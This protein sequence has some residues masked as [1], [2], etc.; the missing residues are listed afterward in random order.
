MDTDH[1]PQS[2]GDRAGLEAGGNVRRDAYWVSLSARDDAEPFGAARGGGIVLNARG[3]ALAAAW[4]ELGDLREGVE[5]DAVLIG[6]R[7]LEG[8]LLLPGKA[9]GTA[10]LGAVLRVFKVISSLRLAQLGKTASLRNTD[11]TGGKAQKAP[12][13]GRKAGKAPA[14]LWK[15][16]YAERALADATALAKARQAMKG[17][18]AR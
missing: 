16:G 17:A 14:G 5:A 3:K 15:K 4:R 12:A 11:V 10:D 2:R 6:P 18:Q 7:T 13:A 1:R 8:I 9:P